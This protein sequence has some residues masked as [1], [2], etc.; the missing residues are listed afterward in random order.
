[1]MRY[2]NRHTC[3]FVK[4]WDYVLIRKTISETV[5]CVYGFAVHDF[6]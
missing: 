2:S 1:M 3:R 5:F 4:P 6:V